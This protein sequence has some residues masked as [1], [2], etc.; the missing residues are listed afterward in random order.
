MHCFVRNSFTDPYHFNLASCSLRGLDQRNTVEDENIA[1]KARGFS[2]SSYKQNGKLRWIG[3]L[4]EWAATNLPSEDNTLL[5]N[6]AHKEGRAHKESRFWRD[7]W[8]HCGSLEKHHGAESGATSLCRAS[9]FFRIFLCFSILAWQLQNGRTFKLGTHPRSRSYPGAPDFCLI[10]LPAPHPT[11]GLAPLHLKQTWDNSLTTSCW[12]CKAQCVIRHNQSLRKARGHFFLVNSLSGMHRSVSPVPCE[13]FS[14]L[15]NFVNCFHG[16]SQP[17][18][19]F[20]KTKQYA[21]GNL[22]DNGSGTQCFQWIKSSHFSRGTRSRISVSYLH[23]QTPL[24]LSSWFER[25]ELRFG[26]KTQSCLDINRSSGSRLIVLIVA[27]NLGFN[28]MRTTHLSSSSNRATPLMCSYTCITFRIW[29]CCQLQNVQRRAHP[30]ESIYEETETEKMWV[31]EVK[32]NAATISPVPVS[33]PSI[34]VQSKGSK[35]AQK[36]C[37]LRVMAFPTNQPIA[38]PSQAD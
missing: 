29:P 16:P 21:E 12:D 26:N 2:F 3:S 20:K 4:S 15:L 35:S 37:K 25:F 19:R 31:K 1:Q 7:T 14:D 10:S 22:A 38:F 13:A 6:R 36:P 8:S 28:L 23:S 33:L 24:E 5:K 9:Y 32:I 17:K 11:F 18:Y 30:R 27:L 34:K